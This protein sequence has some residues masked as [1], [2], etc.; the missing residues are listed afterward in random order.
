[1]GAWDSLD[2]LGKALLSD[3]VFR[4]FCALVHDETGLSFS[5]SSR[6]FVEKRLEN[7]LEALGGIPPEEYIHFLLYD[8][9]KEQEWGRLVDLLTTNETYFMREERQLKCFQKDILPHLV[10]Q[11]P[12]GKIRVW[13]AGCSTGEE[14]YSI[15]ILLHESGLLKDGEVE[16]MATDINTRVLARAREGL[17]TESS[18]RAVDDAF[19]N[20]WFRK[21][22]DG[23][24]RISDEIRQKVKFSRFNLFDLDRYSLFTPFDVIFCRNVII[25]F[26]IE[27]KVKVIERFWEK[28]R[29]GGY[30]LLGHSESLISITD[31]FKLVH[32]PTDLVYTKAAQ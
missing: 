25:Y 14:P 1:M 22:P 29:E 28:M 7:R 30:L 18:F 2:S 12:G 20:R 8:Q 11:R 3:D 31:K 6:F 19:K 26:D 15:V 13:S 23:R 17:Y 10:R 27:A 32:L 5:D 9:E 21:E 24:F 4:R 16:I